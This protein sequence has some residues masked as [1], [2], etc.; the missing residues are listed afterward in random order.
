MQAA[1][2]SYNILRLFLIDDNSHVSWIYCD[3]SQKKFITLSIIVFYY[4]IVRWVQGQCIGKRFNFL[5]FNLS[6]MI[7][8]EYNLFNLS[9]NVE[10]N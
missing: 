5:N 7:K 2:S 10:I 4:N 3:M 8:F 6:K 1:L 9:E